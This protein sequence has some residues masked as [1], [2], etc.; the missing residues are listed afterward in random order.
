MEKTVSKLFL[1]ALLCVS[2]QTFHAAPVAVAHAASADRDVVISQQ[3]PKM[4]GS[5]LSIK[6]VEVTYGVGDGSKPHSHPCVVVGY[7]VDGSITSQ[8]RGAAQQTYKAGQAFYEAPNGIHEI[9]KN[10]SPTQPSKLLA[11]FVCDTD[12]DAPLTLPAPDAAHHAH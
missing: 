4:D 8:V 1:A 2:A 7:V 10:G 3:L 11:I 9:S 5:H 6:L 12:K